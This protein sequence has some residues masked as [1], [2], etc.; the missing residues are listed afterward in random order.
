MLQTL[1]TFKITTVT[2]QTGLLTAF[3]S[4]MGVTNVLQTL[5]LQCMIILHPGAYN[6]ILEGV[7][8]FRGSL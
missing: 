6:T 2:A 5:Q 1:F 7:A 4:P 3:S 8:F